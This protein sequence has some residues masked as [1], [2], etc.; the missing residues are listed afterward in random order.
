MRLPEVRSQAEGH[1]LTLAPVQLEAI[2]RANGRRGFAYFMEM[3]LGKTLTVL[4]EFKALR[5]CGAVERL[6]VIC[7]NCFKGGWANE[8]EKHRTGLKAHHLRERQAHARAIDD[9]R[10]A[11][12]QLRGGAH[13]KRPRCH[14]QLRRRQELLPRSRRERSSSRTALQADQGHH[15]Q[16]AQ[17]ARSAAASPC[18]SIS[19][20]CS[21]A[22]R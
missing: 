8:I 4:T 15:R 21:R 12:H 7:P 16:D 2:T 1:A 20:A 13:A 22:S 3:G 18:S 11:D 14:L 17:A 9:V 5:M 10:C 6:V 19:S